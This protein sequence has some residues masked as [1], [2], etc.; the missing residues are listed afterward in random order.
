M[1]LAHDTFELLC[2]P[3]GIEET[4]HNVLLSLRP[5]GS[6]CADLLQL[7]A[8]DESHLHKISTKTYDV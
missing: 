8:Y 4:P 5:L 7:P 1:D 2:H 3:L 6:A